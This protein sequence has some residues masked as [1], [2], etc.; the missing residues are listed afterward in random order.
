MAV[1]PSLRLIRTH[2]ACSCLSY[3]R[4]FVMSVPQKHRHYSSGPTVITPKDEAHKFM[5][6][7]LLAVGATPENAEIVADNLIEADYRGHYSHGMNRLEMYVRDIEHKLTDPKVLPCTIQENAATAHVDGMN[8]LGAVIGKHCMNIAIQKAKQ[9]GIGFVA[10]KRS[11][12]YGI[13][14]IYALQAIKEG[15]LGFSVTNTSPLMAPTRAKKACLGTNPIALGAPGKDGDC[16]VLDMA[17]TAV[18]LGKVELAIRKGEKIPEGW[19]LNDQGLPETDPKVAFKAAKLTPLG[20]SE[21][22]SGYKGYGLG[23]FVEI[24]SG[25]LAGADYGN[26]I[27]K[28]GSLDKFANLGQAFMAINHKVFAPDFEDRM[29]DLMKML[30]E[31]EPADCNKPVLIQG[32]KERMHMEKV[33]QEGG[34]RYVEHQHNTLNK[35]SKELKIA[36]MVSKTVAIA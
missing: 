9:A 25:I 5:R 10:A 36:P 28:W 21:M 23:M 15:V 1:V 14:G 12:H 31:L 19:A 34:L 18:A 30:R 29:Q 26:Y 35:L 33:H 24:L 8:G 4:I 22:H 7:C 20:G 3:T 17:T 27:R 6:N 13:S 32:D 2:S 16:F 11:N